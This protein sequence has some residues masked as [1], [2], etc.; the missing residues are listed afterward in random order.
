MFYNKP[1]FGRLTTIWMCLMVVILGG[2]FIDLVYAQDN[3]DIP[4]ALSLQS[5]TTVG[6]TLV[7]RQAGLNSIELFLSPEASGT[8]TIALS[9]RSDP[10][11]SYNLASASL[12]LST[13]T[14]PDFYRFAFTPQPDSWQRSYYVLLDVTGSGR[15]QVQQ[16]SGSTYTDGAL[17]YN[18]EPQDAQTVFR[19]GFHVPTMILGY[20]HPLRNW[21]QWLVVSGLVYLLPGWALLMLLWPGAA[22]LAWA[23]KLGLS[24]GVSIAFYPLLLL[25]TDLGH[26]HLGVL[27]AWLPVLAAMAWLL[28]RRRTW[29]PEH[30]PV[31]WHA[32]VRS[33]TFWPDL[34]LILILSVIVGQRL[35]AITTLEAPMWGDA[36]QHTMIAQLFLDNGGLF[37]SWQPYTP[38]ESLTVQFGFPA[39]AALLAWM[40]GNDSIQSTLVAGQIIN[41]LT[42]LTLYP[43]ALLI[44]NGNRW[45]G[46][47]AVLVAGLLSPTPIF[48][49]NWGRYAQLAGQVVLPVALW[50]VCTALQQQRASWR[51]ALLI[52]GVVAG[53]TLTYYRMP[54][55]FAPFVALWLGVW[56]L[57]HWRANW[58]AWGRAL[59]FLG[60]TAGLAI[61]LVL[62]WAFNVTRGT[63]PQ[64]VGAGMV[65]ASPMSRVVADY[66][67]WRSVS[68]F[69]P[70]FL[71]LTAL[72][73]LIWGMI[74]RHWTIVLVGVWTLILALYVAGQLI[75]L[76]GTNMMQSFAVIISLYIPV[77]LI[78][79]WLLSQAITLLSH[80]KAHVWQIVPGLVLCCVAGWAGWQPMRQVKPL[81]YALVTRPDSQAMTWIEQNT[82]ANALFLVEGFRIYGGT[83]AVGADAGWWIPLFTGRANTMP[84][85]YAMLNERPAQPGYTRRVV[86]LV[87]TL[88]THSPAS[89]EGL[90]VL[91]DWGITHVYIGQGQG[92]IGSGAIPLFAPA[93]LRTSPAFDLV[94][95][96]D[97][98]SIFALA[99]QHC[100]A[101]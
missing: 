22:S 61:L 15:V 71:L 95:H 54:F 9:L 91:C 56:G 38:Y 62:P 27:Y 43:L 48:Y 16:V 59:L 90:T 4:A 46:V 89:A 17:Y 37:D 3:P 49:V 86:D 65:T 51:Q 57:T 5:S 41:V 34:A 78:S 55:Y 29:R 36:Y 26:L 40:S 79:G 39:A 99:P 42:V 68:S 35:S 20:A 77:A 7:A 97:R 45:A 12:P 44:A 98:V 88:E 75:R 80:R 25:W 24:A 63:L 101:R 87:A 33:S 76:P 21:G 31:A 52:G 10:Q 2:G 96:Q 67:V 83:S 19:P 13:V 100:E 6:Q 85:Q 60:M 8:G 69:M 14:H 64:T 82:P 32:W 74:R 73:G 23:E 47:G 84:P 11:S 94:Y 28:W 66:Q 18:G 92:R 50:L 72:A 58:G 93:D 1:M 53:M 81:E 70:W 30:I